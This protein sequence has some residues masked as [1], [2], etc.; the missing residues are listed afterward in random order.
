ME[1]CKCCGKN[2]AD[3]KNTHYL[4]DGIIRSALNEGGL[5]IRGKGAM[6]DISSH[7]NS[8]EFKFQQKTSQEAIIE[9]L[10]HAPGE[11]EIEEAKKNDFSVD[12]VF[13]SS[14]EKIFTEIETEFIDKILPKLRGKD[15][16]GEREVSFTE[17]LLIRKF[18]L[19]QV[20]RT[21]I[22]DQGYKIS[23]VLQDKL[24]E[25]VLN[26]NADIAMIKSVPL[27]VTY[28]STLG[29][30]FEYTYNDVGIG[31]E[32]GNHVIIFND[33]I[34]QVFEKISEVKYVDFFGVN[35]KQTLMYFTN[36]NEE[37]FKFKVFDNDGRKKIMATFGAFK[38]RNQLAFYVQDLQNEF[39]KRKGFLPP[40]HVINIFVHQIINANSFD[41]LQRY[42]SARYEKIKEFLFQIL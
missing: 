3:K 1:I 8:V 26:K 14:C 42:S 37:N 27:N 28:L 19:L 16:T 23:A 22:C 41:D 30:N 25:I 35:E 39:L 18:F 34:I 2:P 9:G 21:S 31:S 29:G 40:R 36:Q 15:F 33:F 24:R 17:Y 7:K 38:V 4:T 32:Q 6:Y 10:G 13:C 12:N 11:K 5:N 20:L